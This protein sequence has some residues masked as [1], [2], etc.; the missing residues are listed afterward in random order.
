[1]NPAHSDKPPRRP[2]LGAHMSI[3]GGYHEAVERAHR[4]GC[5]CVQLFTKNNNQWRA[6]EIEP[7][8]VREFQGALSRRRITH[9]LSHSSYLINLASPNDELWKKSIDAFVVEIQRAAVLGIPWVVL[10]PGAS[11]DSGEKAGLKRVIRALR[12]V[13]KQ[14]RSDA[15]GCLLETTAGQGTCLGHSFEHLATILDGVPDTSRLGVCL[16]TCHVFA[17]GYAMDTQEAY[18]R[19]MGSC[20]TLI[21]LDRIKAFHLNDS[22]RELGCRVDRHDHIGRGQLGKESFRLLLNDPRFREIPMYLET[23]KGEENGRDLDKIN[24]ATLRRLCAR[25]TAAC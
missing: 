17:A 6:K 12:E 19:M 1:M 15:T 18:D 11:M 8:E 4:A 20:A 5:D 2:I 22:R 21:G 25:R 10:H 16:D 14:T 3:A 13:L 23:P 9:P 24:L 7:D